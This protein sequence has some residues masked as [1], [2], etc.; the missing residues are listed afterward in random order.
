M[1]VFIELALIENFC[2]DFVLL[3]GAKYISKN[4]CG[5]RRI[6]LGSA[7]GAAFAVVFPLIS[8]G[9]A[10]SVIVKLLSGLFICLVSGRFKSLKSFIKFAG[11]FLVLTALL[12][13]IL[14]GLFALTGW[15]YREGEGFLL[16][17]VPIGIPLFCALML[18]LGARRLAKKLQKG[19]KN[20]VICRIYAGQAHVEL[21][22]FFDSGNKVYSKGV[23]VSVIPK[24]SAEKLI[25]ES[26]INEGVIIHTVAGSRTIKV[27]TADRMEI[28]IGDKPKIID[29]VKIGI[30]P[31]NINRAVLH[32][33]LL[34]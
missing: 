26:R 16:S 29:K 7:I 12:G 8:F 3:V 17:S 14:V 10:L 25:D 22:G 6:C 2:M 31:Q 19:E 9:K 24:V 32:C 13:G 30:S 5:Y 11:W 20:A 15:E 27:F 21:Q 23:P 34:E 18:I 28:E 1:Q 4:P 33:D